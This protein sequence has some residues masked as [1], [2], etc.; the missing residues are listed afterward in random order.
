MFFDIRM[1]VIAQQ[2]ADA[3]VQECQLSI[4]MLKLVEVK[5]K[6]VF[7]RVGRRH[8]SHTRSLFR[9]A[10][11]HRRI[12]PN[13]QRPHGIAMLKPHPMLFTFTPDGQFQIFGQR[14]DHRNANAVQ[15]AGH[16]ISVVVRCVLKLAACVQLGHDDLCR[17]N[18]FFLVHARRNTAAIIFDRHRTIGVKFN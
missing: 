11:D 7:E 15:A 5:F 9:L 17:R 14:I 10:I 4:P 6:Y 1:P 3:R 18:A 13:N 2:Y 16:L 8:E 12:T